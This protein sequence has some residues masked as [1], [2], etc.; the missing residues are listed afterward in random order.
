MEKKKPGN[1]ALSQKGNCCMIRTKAFLCWILNNDKNWNVIE[2]GVE[3]ESFSKHECTIDTVGVQELNESLACS[4]TV[5]PPSAKIWRKLI[6]QYKTQSIRNIETI[7]LRLLSVLTSTV[8]LCKI[9]VVKATMKLL[10]VGEISFLNW[11]IILTHRTYRS[12]LPF[13]FSF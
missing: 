11:S 1:T 12:A 2:Q 9:M 10:F 8:L 13:K 6:D 4:W 5:M 7:T 3:I